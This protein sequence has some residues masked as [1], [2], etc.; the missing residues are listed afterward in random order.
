[1]SFLHLK[2]EGQVSDLEDVG[3]AVRHLTIDYLKLKFQSGFTRL[4]KLNLEG[5][6]GIAF[7]NDIME[8]YYT[9]YDFLGIYSLS[10]G[11][12]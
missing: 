12:H 6:V 4:V 9:S 7:L 8:I 5:L 2:D 11:P 1:L 10:L 3:I